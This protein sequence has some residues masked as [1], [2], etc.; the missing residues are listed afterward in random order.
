MKR[1]LRLYIQFLKQ[2]IK[3][4]IEYKADF[5]VGIIGF[6]LIQGS[7]IIFI[8]LVFNTIPVLAG[9]SF[10]EILFIYGFAQIPKGIDHVFT[11]Y[12]WI[13]A[14]NTVKKGD[15]DRYLLRPLNPLFQVIVERF[16]PDGFGEIGVGIILLVTSWINIGLEV[17]VLRIVMLVFLIICG[18]FIYT[19][20]KLAAASA[21][22]WI[23]D[24]MGLV[25][26][27][28]EVSNFVK[29]P[30]NIYPK[31]VRFIMSGIVPFAFTY[32]GI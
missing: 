6:L 27:V 17:T 9:W 7:G 30:I 10:Y 11:D 25:R 31:A 22:F 21:A 19:A 2:Y 5:I 15:F 13:F 1:Y 16:Q 28:Y 4:L 12:L 3:T 29:Y 23:K 18:T 14:S 26:V 24:S 32:Y 8:S 20:I